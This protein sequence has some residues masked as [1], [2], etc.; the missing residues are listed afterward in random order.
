MK[1]KGRLDKQTMQIRVDSTA[2]VQKKLHRNIAKAAVN[3]LD[4]MRA[5]KASELLASINNN[6]HGEDVLTGSS[7]SENVENADNRP[8][9]CRLQFYSVVSRMA[10]RGGAGINE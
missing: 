5:R 2:L 3:R 4:R 8:R 10:S 9:G 6:G 1:R 7:L